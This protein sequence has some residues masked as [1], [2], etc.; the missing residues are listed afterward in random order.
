MEVCSK[1][2]LDQNIIDHLSLALLPLLA[3]AEGSTPATTQKLL[4]SAVPILK[5]AVKA[6][7]NSAPALSAVL[8]CLNHV[9]IMMVDHKPLGSAVVEI[10]TLLETVLASTLGQLVS[11]IKK[12]ADTKG[13]SFP[14]DLKDILG[15]INALI[16]WTKMSSGLFY[17]ARHV[18]AIVAGHYVYSQGVVNILVPVIQVV[19]PVGAQATD[20]T[21]SC[22]GNAELDRKLNLLKK[23]ALGVANLIL[24]Y[25]YSTA[26]ATRANT[27]PFFA[28]CGAVGPLAL[29]TLLSICVANHDKLEEN[30]SEDALGGIIVEYLRI[31]CNMLEDNSFYHFFS[32]N[33]PKLIV[34]VI[35]PLLK[36]T[37]EEKDSL[38]N[39]PQNFVNL[40]LDT[41][42]KQSS[43]IPKTEAAKLLEALCDHID[44]ALTFTAFFC[45][46]SIRYAA[47]AWT[48]EE[49][50]KNP[51]LSTYITTSRLLTKSSQEDI[52]ETCLMAMTDISYST[53]SR[54]DIFLLF[55]KVLSENFSAIF[56]T[57]SPL[58]KCRAALMLGYYADNLFQQ[59][60]AL[61]VK[62]VE[63]L[64]KG[65]SHE[66]EEKAFSL[67]CSDTLKSVIAD[68]DMISRIE[69]FVNRLFPYLSS[70]VTKMEVPTFFDI[71]MTM[72]SS[73][74]ESIDASI[75]QLLDSLVIRIQTEY[76]ALR[77]KGEKN[78][79]VLNQCWNVIRCICENNAF[80]PEFAAAIEHSLLP[81]F[82]YLV[83]PKD[84]EF[85]DDM[86]QII[87]T[88]IKKSKAVSEN[89]GKV[90]PV[91]PKFFEKYK[92]VFGSL[93]HTLNCYLFYG[94]ELFATH[95]DWIEIVL[96]MAHT[97]LF[98][99]EQPVE[100]NN[101]EGAIL[102]QMTLQTLGGGLMDPYIPNIMSLIAKRLNIPPSADYLTRQLYNI[103]L[104]S[105]CNNGPLTLTSLESHLEPVISGII[106]TAKTYK[107][108]Y[109]R[110]V[111]V[112]GLSN[113]LVHG[114]LPGFADKYYPKILETIVTAL[115]QQKAEDTRRMLKAD[116]QVI[117]L[118]EE[119]G[120]SSE[121]ESEEEEPQTEET[122]GE[123]MMSEAE[124]GKEEAKYCFLQE[125]NYNRKSKRKIDGEESDD[126]LSVRDPL[127]SVSIF[128]CC[129]TTFLPSFAKDGSHGD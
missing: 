28:F 100:I 31:L 4:E 52:I 25:V 108:S 66:K 96:R 104:C 22:T 125:K 111:L 119:N 2:E 126:D 15:K 73:Y 120:E 64:I 110:K 106:S 45:C 16:A 54:K 20:T 43:D 80:Y 68:Q 12:V 127:D 13:E 124:K 42:D 87:T 37:E 97:S 74:A 61:F 27:T 122:K 24:G 19:V 1:Y 48:L 39:D 69:A 89:M 91:L 112:I 41:C 102:F 107:E 10:L 26:L 8:T 72:I 46:E 29:M 32:E 82:N 118:E 105:V 99:Q 9:L 88:L 129:G 94:K 113:V 71:L 44:G 114:N 33:K 98:T 50:K 6:S 84:I 56:D 65:I 57:A 35:L 30:V 11:T 7:E 58:I 36:S 17:K 121:D 38:I 63:F 86:V 103:V 77:A 40:A 34:D 75:I 116:R 18:G 5:D 79:M 51:V 78:N 128:F 70:M 3:P 60:H 83:D 115:Q 21:V 117:T 93:L 81:L 67:Q 109:D 76:N 123:E 92:G 95:K 85:D 47:R 59:D 49:A 14:V 23:K 90:F 101:T 55:E 62:I 53:P